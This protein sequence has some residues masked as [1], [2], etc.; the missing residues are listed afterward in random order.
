MRAHRGDHG[1]RHRHRQPQ[2]LSG[3]AAQDGGNCRRAKNASRPRRHRH[4]PFQALQR[5]LR[6]PDR[7]PGPAPRHITMRE[8]VKR[9]ATSPASAARNSASSCRIRAWRT[10][11]GRGGHPPERAQPGAGEALDRG[12]A[13][14]DHGID[15]RREFRPGETAIGAPRPGGPVHVRRQAHGPEPHRRRTPTSPTPS[16]SR[17]S[18]EGGQRSAPPALVPR[19]CAA[20]SRSTRAM[21]GALATVIPGRRRRARNP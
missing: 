3:H 12:I 13:R 1:P 7:R 9:R 19:S 2:A 14:Q 4:R 16:G 20:A 6:P 11:G 5:R 21:G 17:T 15:G 8:Q 10:R 18:P